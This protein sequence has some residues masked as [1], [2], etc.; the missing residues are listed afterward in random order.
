MHPPPAQVDGCKAAHA[1]DMQ[2]RVMV[3][4]ATNFPWDIDE[5][6]KWVRACCTCP[7]ARLGPWGMGRDRGGGR[8]CRGREYGGRDSCGQAGASTTNKEQ[9]P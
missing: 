3:L 4:A 1:D 9:G 8:R 2:Q 7:C 5:A 6:F